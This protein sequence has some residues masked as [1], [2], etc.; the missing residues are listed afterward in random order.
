M[1][2]FKTFL[3]V[4]LVSVAG[5][6]NAYVLDEST[7]IVTDV[8]S[9]KEWLQ[10]TETTNLSINSAL[11]IYENDGWRLASNADMSLLFNDFF[12][13]L[14]PI[15][16]AEDETTRQVYTG[17]YGDGVDPVVELGRRF[18][19]TEYD[20]SVNAASGE[21][22]LFEEYST[23]I[24]KFGSDIGGDTP[25][26]S[27]SMNSEFTFDRSGTQVGRPERAI[28]DFNQYSGVANGNGRI[29]VAL[30]RDINRSEVPEPT[31]MVLLALGLFGLLYVRRKPFG[32]NPQWNM[33]IA[34]VVHNNRSRKG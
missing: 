1:K 27:L 34:P 2:S 24:V 9:G 18:G 20:Q 7:K 10:W 3:S 30:I 25:F 5:A 21:T 31:S 14:V 17:V 4:I 33:A 11:S 29:G 32:H 28:F 19:W 16:L 23:S 22:V 6:S 12:A 13:P 8:A 15:A 26:N